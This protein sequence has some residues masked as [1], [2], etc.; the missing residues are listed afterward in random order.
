MCACLHTL[1]LTTLVPKGHTHRYIKPAMGIGTGTKLGTRAQ[2]HTHSSNRY[3]SVD[4]QPPN[5][6]VDGL[7]L[8]GQAGTTLHAGHH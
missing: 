1:A 3:R 6:G 2:T 4:T 8:L 7:G 5:P